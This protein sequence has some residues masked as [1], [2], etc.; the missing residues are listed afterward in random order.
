MEHLLRHL[1]NQTAV[2]NARLAS[3]ELS[4]RRVEREEVEIFLAQH[5]RS[6]RVVD[7]LGRAVA[8]R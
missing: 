2:D 3:R 5:R 8:G 1:G 6:H 4:R 7:D